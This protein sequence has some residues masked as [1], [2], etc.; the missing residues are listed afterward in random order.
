MMLL[1]LKIY[2]NFLQ[3]VILYYFESFCFGDL[4]GVLLIIVLTFICFYKTPSKRDPLLVYVG[5]ICFFIGF[6]C[7]VLG[8]FFNQKAFL[9]PIVF[10]F[11]HSF[12][13][14]YVYKNSTFFIKS[15]ISIST[16]AFLCE[17]LFIMANLLRLLSFFFL[18]TLSLYI[19][20]LIYQ[21]GSVI[22]NEILLYF[23]WTGQRLSKP[24]LDY[25]FLEK[26]EYFSLFFG[27]LLFIRLRLP[28][29][30]K[31]QPLYF[32]IGFFFVFLFIPFYPIVDGFS[33]LKFSD[34]QIFSVCYSIYIIYIYL[35][36]KSCIYTIEYLAFLGYFV[37]LILQGYVLFL[38]IAVTHYFLVLFF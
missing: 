32:S 23:Y 7:V 6:Y 37:F 11:L 15:L 31:N 33:L 18:I 22:F 10:L 27:A 3:T 20:F 36:Y 12:I 25:F 9:F 5:L 26:Y 8:F 28:K 13:F 17:F 1:F 21:N 2:L 16:N 4:S 29:P 14:F 34:A 38:V 30:I 19:I 35:K 24:L